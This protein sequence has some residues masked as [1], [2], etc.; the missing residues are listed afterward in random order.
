MKSIVHKGKECAII[1]FTIS[2]ILHKGNDYLTD[3]CLVCADFCNRYADELEQYK[4]L[5]Y[6][7]KCIKTCRKCAKACLEIANDNSSKDFSRALRIIE[8]EKILYKYKYQDFFHE[9]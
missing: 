9:S 3:I 5:D 1:C 7:K 2:N 6:C 8:S 4:E